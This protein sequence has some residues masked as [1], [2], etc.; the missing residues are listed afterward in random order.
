MHEDG[1]KPLNEKAH[2]YNF[3]LTYNGWGFCLLTPPAILALPKCLFKAWR[4]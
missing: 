2:A 4:L 1:D 3:S